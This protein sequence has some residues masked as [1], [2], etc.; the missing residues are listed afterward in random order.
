[1]AGPKNAER[2]LQAPDLLNFGLAIAI[3]GFL[4]GYKPGFWWTVIAAIVVA[5]PLSF[6][7]SLV[8]TLRASAYLRAH[9]I[10]NE[11]QRQVLQPG[12]V[13]RYGGTITTILVTAGIVSLFR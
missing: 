4:G 10:P 3:G 12:V 8:S 5:A 1:M 13:P 2:W 7:T 6:I 9:G 11:L